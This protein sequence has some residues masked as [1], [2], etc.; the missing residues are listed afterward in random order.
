MLAIFAVS[1]S[2]DDVENRPIVEAGDAAVLTAPEE[3]NVYVLTPENM[4]ALGERFVWTA[5]NF[6]AGVIPNYAIEIDRAGDNFDTPA[7]IG[8]TNGTTQFAASQSVLNTALLA[9]GAVPY[10]SANFEVRVKA[11]VGDMFNYSN[12]AEMIITPYTTETPKIYAV[13]NF[14]AASG[15]GNDWTP[16]DGVPLESSGFGLTDFEGYVY[17]NVPTPEFKLLPTNENFDGDFGD[18]GSFAGMLT[19]SGAGEANIPLSGPGYYLI[20]A[21]TGAVTASNPEGMTY[22]AQPTAWGIIGS[23]TPT[24]WDSDTDMTY[25]PATKKWTITLNLIGGQ[26]IKFRANDAWDLNFGDDG[27]NGS[28]EAGGANIAI[29]T[30]GSYTV[31]L[32]L[33]NP[34]Q[35]T[36]SVTAN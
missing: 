8:I 16:A 20:K 29:P 18:D 13:G 28:L 6:G 24:G 21:N 14:Q 11:Y 2:T 34:R 19:Q 31:T 23:A 30:S 3:G 12:V 10:E 25:D 27:A 22:T 35:Y 9:V 32:D 1:C 15:Y 26:E 7:T 17:M 33:S 5:A 4:D 36:Y